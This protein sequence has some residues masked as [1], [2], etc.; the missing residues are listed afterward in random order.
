M[1]GMPEDLIESPDSRLRLESDVL[2]DILRTLRLTGTRQFCMT[3]EGAWQTDDR[4]RLG[5]Q[6]ANR[7]SALPFHIVAEGTCWLKIE[8]VTATLREGDIVAFPF[9]TGH[10]LGA[11]SGGPTIVP[12]N[13]LPTVPWREL[14]V[15][16]YGAGAE[17]T[18]LLCGYLELDRLSY[19]P[20]QAALPRFIHV[21]TAHLPAD[22]WLAATVRQMVSEA[23]NPRFGGF[24]MLERL[25]EVLFIELIRHHLADAAVEATGLVAALRDPGIARCLALI[26]ADPG[27]P[28][29]LTELAAASGLSRSVFAERFQTL[30]GK[31][32]ISYVRDWRLHL[33]SLDLALS[34]KTI[35]AVAQDAGY[36]TEAAFSRAFARSYGSPPARWR[37]TDQ[38]G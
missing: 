27:A 12:T 4:A 37:Q 13:D 7:T 9:T 31:T 3:A 11:G 23:D 33:A 1:A 19:Q 18:R 35:L 8:D 26:H 6:K 29:S 28:R 15:L 20:L 24:S 25:T 36:G 14:P 38:P 30:L 34:Q 32:P 22:A 21:Q 16:H 2:S 17:R 10:Q 5:S